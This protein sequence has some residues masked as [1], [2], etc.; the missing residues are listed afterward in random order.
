VHVTIA[1]LGFNLALPNKTLSYS[2]SVQHDWINTLLNNILKVNSRTAEPDGSLTLTLNLEPADDKL[3][4]YNV[5]A[6]FEGDEPCSATA[7]SYTPNGTEYAVCTTFQYGFKP[8]SN[9]TWLTVEPQST[10]VMQ[11]TKTPEQMQQE[12]EESGWL[13]IWHEFTW[14]YPW[15][16]LHFKFTM[17]GAKID[18]GFNPA[19][20]GGETVEYSGLESAFPQLTAEP[21]LTPEEIAQIV[22]EA[23]VEAAIGTLTAS[24][25]AIAAANTRI[26]FATAVALG[27]Y[28]GFLTGMV[29]YAWS[30][31]SSGAQ[32]KAKAFLIGLVVDL[33][34]VA[35]VTFMSVRAAF[36]TEMVATILAS[37]F[38]H[39]F[40]PASL[41]V[42]VMVATA[43]LFTN[44]CVGITA[45]VLVPEPS[46][47][48]FK[49][50]F[51]WISLLFSAIALNIVG[52]RS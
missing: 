42:A 11:P 29:A 32:T 31:Y 38:S 8:A 34:G 43:A 12:A 52:V 16:R 22:E 5:R 23:V 27:V 39:L 26:P 17:N 2:K 14:W 41:N 7:Y 25:T 49:L 20:P 46:S 48:A 21:G 13:S 45:L 10:Q 37:A 18:V 44:I 24:V 19:L 9:A 40:D 3:T 50:T 4:A 47:V 36:I 51:P 33:W 35:L 6:V 30:I 1:S 28:A 15:Y